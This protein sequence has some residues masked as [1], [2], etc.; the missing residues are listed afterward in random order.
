MIPRYDIREIEAVTNV[1]KSGQLSS[2]FKC[3]NG[4]IQVQAFEKEFAEYIGVKHAI[5]V[6]NGTVS[7]EIALK[8]AGIG[9]GDEVIT[10]PLSFIATA[11][12]ILAVGAVPVFV[13][14][15]PHTLNI[16]VPKIVDAITPKTKAVIPVS[17]LGYPAPMPDLLDIEVEQSLF[18]L[19]DAAQALGASISGQKCGSFST[20]SFSFQETKQLTSLGEGGAITTNNDE[21][22]NICRN[23]RNHGNYYGALASSVSTNARLTEAAAAFGRIQ[24]QKLDMFN[25]M[26]TENAEYFL[27]HIKPPLLPI[28]QPDSFY[29]PTYSMIGMVLDE[30]ASFEREELIDYLTVKGISKG[31]PGQNVGFYKTLIYETPIF[32]P[33]QPR[34]P[35][36]WAEQ[37]LP[38]IVL[39]DVHR[40]HTKDEVVAA[41]DVINEVTEAPK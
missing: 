31:V 5:S 26:Q 17:L 23:I 16:D 36:Y 12:A 35:C 40:W 10:S 37:L 6:C 30:N 24:L 7:L 32:R 18:I 27:S 29:S 4:G 22:A 38:K 3:F 33:Y 2:F 1:I 34:T 13:D 11:T 28:Y 20:G 41:V 21:F 25:W 19:E 39:F 9:H 8:A 15:D 14:I